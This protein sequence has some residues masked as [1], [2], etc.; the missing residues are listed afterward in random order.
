VAAQK[1]HKEIQ[2][3][4]VA[5]LR[6]FVQDTMEH[7]FVKQDFTLGRYLCPGAGTLAGIHMLRD[8]QCSAPG[9]SR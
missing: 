8:E 9:K 3:S 5:W 4:E 1:E 2:E 6:I 7:C